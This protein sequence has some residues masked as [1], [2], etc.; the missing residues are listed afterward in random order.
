MTTLR[1]DTIVQDFK[2]ILDDY[3]R[4]RYGSAEKELET[5]AV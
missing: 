1:G 4:S 2:K 5:T 3:V